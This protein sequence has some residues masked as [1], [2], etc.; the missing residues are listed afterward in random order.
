M[1]TQALSCCFSGHRRMSLGQ[2]FS[3]YSTLLK[4]I[5]ELISRGVINYYCGGALGFDL[6]AGEAVVALRREHPEIR[7]Y[8]VLP[9]RDQDALWRPRDRQRYAALL[10]EADEITYVSD[11]Y[12]NTCM[13]ERNR[14]LV[15]GSNVCVCYLTKESGGTYYTVG[16][17]Y[18]AGLEIINLGGRT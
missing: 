7:L 6:L 16:Q 18:K 17:A 12:T 2:A 15:A 1:E 4:T 13:M 11:V 5:N 3:A 8:M 9:C 10:S 14:K